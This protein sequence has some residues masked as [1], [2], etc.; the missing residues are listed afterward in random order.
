MDS[1]LN[2]NKKE[3]T[4]FLIEK[5]YEVYKKNFIETTE[6]DPVFKEIPVSIKQ[7][8]VT[9]V[10]ISKETLTKKKTFFDFNPEKAQRQELAKQQSLLLSVETQKKKEKIESTIKTIEVEIA[11]P[12][13]NEENVYNLLN[14]LNEEFSKINLFPKAFIE[15]I[16]SETPNERKLVLPKEQEKIVQDISLNKKEFILSKENFIDLLTAK[17]NQFENPVELFQLEENEFLRNDLT[18]YKLFND[19]ELFSLTILLYSLNDELCLSTLKNILQI[20]SYYYIKEEKAENLFF[21]SEIVIKEE[22][23]LFGIKYKPIILKDN[24]NNKEINLSLLIQEYINDLLKSDFKILRQANIENN[25]SDDEKKEAIKTILDKVVS[26][27]ED[28]FILHFETVSENIEIVGLAE[29]RIK[30]YINEGLL[31]KG[32]TEFEIIENF[33]QYFLTSDLLN[34]SKD[35]HWCGAFIAFCYKDFVKKEIKQKFMS[36]TYRFAVFAQNTE[37]HLGVQSLIKETSEIF[38]NSVFQVSNNK[39]LS[40]EEKTE[41]INAGINVIKENLN[42]VFLKGYIVA[43]LPTE[44]EW[45][46]SHFGIIV[47]GEVYAEIINPETGE[48][49]ETGN[50]DI[51]FFLDVIEGNVG[52]EENTTSRSVRKVAR[53]IQDIFAVYR[54]LPEDYNLEFQ[55]KAK[56]EYNN[57]EIIIKDPLI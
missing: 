1:P 56:E 41:K 23:L 3:L 28:E 40:Q 25:L 4:L 37:R 57:A 53:N 18:N 12:I 9:P 54:F 33:G 29:E 5:S 21:L 50:G 43:M 16:S 36:S 8:I 14:Y 10:N 27:A 2:K 13:V 22:E 39:K 48:I 6:K 7:V 30:S 24:T 45:Y 11:E 17:I 34:T 51:Y 20:N 55:G 35:F 52:A 19:E 32:T 26:I 15:N 46:G 31:W 47:H 38:Q 42:K 49:S 44:K